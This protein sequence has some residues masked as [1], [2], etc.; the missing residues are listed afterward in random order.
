MSAFAVNNKFW[1]GIDLAKES[2]DISIAPC[3]WSPNAWRELPVVHFSYPP[4]SKEG[5]NKILEW[6]KQRAEL[7]LCQ[8]ICVESTGKFSHRFAQAISERGLPPVS[9]INPNRSK[10][11]ARSLGVKDKTDDVDAAI[12]ALFGT[13][14]QPPPS[15][16]LSE[17]E[18]ELRELNRL[19]AKFVKDLIAWKCRLKDADYNSS[20]QIITDTIKSIEDKI[21]LIEE[22]LSKIVSRDKELKQQVEWIQNVRGLGP[23][24]AY[25][26]TAEF[27][28]LD[29]YKRNELVASGGLYPVKK[30]SANTVYCKPKLAKG[31]GGKVRRVLYMGSLTLFKTESPLMSIF[32]DRLM[33]GG[34]NGQCVTGALMRKLLLI[35]RAVVKS[36][37]VYDETKICQRTEICAS[38]S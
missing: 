25:T 30:V 35:A 28:R 31:G 1:I 10:G 21:E 34:K 26:M 24:N 3:G 36:G 33:K 19:R 37:G 8:G 7:K 27:G 15:A 13:M 38:C 32:A 2:F 4:N 29:K 22:E 16:P 6:I 18:K 17:A 5:I 14:H 11:L 23:V 20:K 9:I 12:L